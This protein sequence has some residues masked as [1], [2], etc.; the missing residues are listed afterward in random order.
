M[1]MQSY[2]H[3]DDMMC[4]IN[5]TPFVDVMLV[6]L[7]VFLVTLPLVHQTINIDLPK[8]TNKRLVNPPSPINISVNQE[9]QYLVNK[10]LTNLDQLKELLKKES[11]RDPKPVVLLYADINTRY[12]DIVR[13]L[14]S[15]HQSGLEKIGFVT[16]EENKK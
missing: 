2:T 4:E 12:E 16:Q 14:G 7:V 5:M 1:S 9:G 15:I 11:H 8:V 3:D 10:V 13:V 6:L